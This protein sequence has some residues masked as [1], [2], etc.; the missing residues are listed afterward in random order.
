MKAHD[1]SMAT[2]TMATD[3]DDDPLVTS[4]YIS[5]PAPKSLRVVCYGSSS[6]KTPEKYL[7]EARALGFILALRG[8]VCVNGAGSFGCMAAM[9]AGAASGNGHI[10]G[11]IHEMWVV[12]GSDWSANVVDAGAHDVFTNPADRDGP[13]RELLVAGGDDLQERKKLLVKDADAL[14]V[15]PGGPGTW[16]EVRTKPC[17]RILMCDFCSLE[18]QTRVF[19]F[20]CGKWL[21]LDRLVFRTFQ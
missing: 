2:T 15:L 17:R 16:D 13:I 10:V 3:S 19:V 4:E 14:I 18:S 21:V 11:V 8:H 20:S 7:M 12:D 6:S 5:K 9:N 1:S